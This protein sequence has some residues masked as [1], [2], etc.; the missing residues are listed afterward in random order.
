MRG[1]GGKLPFV[2]MSSSHALAFAAIL[3]RDSWTELGLGVFSASHRSEAE[4]GVEEIAAGET[5]EL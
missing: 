2:R 4:E 5:R 1:R 3:V